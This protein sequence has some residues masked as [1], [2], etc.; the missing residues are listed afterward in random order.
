[1][2]RGYLIFC[3]LLALC[4]L[5]VCLPAAAERLEVVFLDAGKADAFILFTGNSTVVI[6]TGKDKM[7]KK[8]VEFLQERGIER[9]DAMFITHFDKD[10][11]G[12]ADSLLEKLPVSVVYEPSYFSD[13]KQYLQYREALDAAQV[14]NV[15]L[16]ENLSFELDGVSYRVDVANKEDYGVDE[17]NDFSLVISVTYGQTSFLFAGD[18][19][20]ARLGELLAEG[21]LAHDVLKAPHHGAAEKLSAAFFAAVNPKYAVITSD[22]E[23]PEDPGVVQALQDLGTEVYLTR[24]GGVA[25]VSDGETL[26]FSQLPLDSVK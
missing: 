24:L 22:E 6:D 7:G 1:M 11:V 9:I 13:G 21:N 16:T 18:A 8:M 14:R 15:R 20:N 23:K 4:L 17:E 3:T 19:E 26:T 2:K 5:G 10:H 25:C 12:G